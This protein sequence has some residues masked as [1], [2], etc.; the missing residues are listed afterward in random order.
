M[1]PNL[2]AFAPRELSQ[3]AVLCW[4]LSWADPATCETS[5]TLHAFGVEFLATLFER[6]NRQLPLLESV[7]VTR[8]VASIDV[9]VVV[10]DQVALIIEHKVGTSEHS[11]Q[12]ERYL[13]VARTW[14]HAQEPIAIYLQTGEQFSYHGVAS[15]GYTLIDRGD[16]LTLFESP[17]SE[18][19]IAQSDVL[20]DYARYLRMV[21]EEALAYATLPLRE[22]GGNRRF[23]YGFFK[24][25]DDAFGQAHWW[26]Y[27]PNARGGFHCYTWVTN[28][29]EQFVQLEET[30][31]C[32][33]IRVDDPEHYARLRWEWHQA[34]V[35]AGQRHGLPLVKPKRFGYGETMTVA[36]LDGDYRAS[37]R[38]GSIDF[39]ATLERLRLVERVFMDAVRQREAME[40]AEAL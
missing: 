32:F 23:W 2:F 3:D 21:E 5:P 39:D 13:A 22:W 17:V 27:V 29:A 12:L 4:I 1:R 18:A 35:Q 28:G 37:S 25:L 34:F 14:G 11:E 33:K 24:R 20:G 40:V 8:Q 36:I 30:R 38:D 7:K 15:A 19:A 31:L 26:G 6:A 16:L 10:N 9:H